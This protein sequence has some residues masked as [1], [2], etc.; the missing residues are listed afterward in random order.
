MNVRV[1]VKRVVPV[2]YRCFYA[3]HTV[4]V[5]QRVYFGDFA[6]KRFLCG[7]IRLYLH[8]VAQFY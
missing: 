5:N 2:V 4:T 6:S 8:F 7:G 3:N 1:S